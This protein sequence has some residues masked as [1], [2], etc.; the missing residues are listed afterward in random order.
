MGSLYNAF[1]DFLTR[2]LNELPAGD[3]GQKDLNELKKTLTP[4]FRQMEE[5]IG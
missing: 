4:L 5:D 1:A 3:Q 2:L